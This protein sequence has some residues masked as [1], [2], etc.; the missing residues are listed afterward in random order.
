M[1]SIISAGTTSGTS[2]NLSGD[3]TG[4]LAFQTQNGTN[5]IT[6][7]NVSASLDAFPA[8]T[9]L[10]F[11]QTAA[12]TGWTKDTSHDNK[13]LRIVS[14]AA[15]SGGSVAFTTAFSSQNVG[16]TTLSTSQIPSHTHTAP[17]VVLWSTYSGGNPPTLFSGT[18]SAANSGV[19]D[20]TYYG[21]NTGATGGGGS[22]T[23]SLNI[24]VQ[25]VDVII[26]AKN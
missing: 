12:P 20:S 24:E 11:Q 9:K 18:T 22:H 23:H 8:G 10:I 1:A 21:P 26:A 13:A 6:V 3:T 7:P 19:P 14:G 17:G 2:L 16:A 25:Y 15:S 4:N 5:T